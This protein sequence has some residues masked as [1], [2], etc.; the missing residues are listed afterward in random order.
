MNKK[1]HLVVLFNL[2]ALHTPPTQTFNNDTELYT[3]GL[4][5]LPRPSTHANEVKMCGKLDGFAGPRTRPPML[6]D[7]YVQEVTVFE[8]M[9]IVCGCPNT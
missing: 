7:R 2:P 4:Y 3:R 9:L 6:R 5:T 8:R 1:N